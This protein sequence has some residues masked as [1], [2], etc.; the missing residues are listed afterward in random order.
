MTKEARH[1]YGPVP[2]RRLGLSLGV[3]IVPFNVCTLDCLY[4]QLGKTAEK[5]VQRKDYVPV[6]GVLTELRD[7]LAQGLEADYVTISGSGEPTL[8]RDLGKIVQNMKRITNIPVAIVTNGTLLYRQDVRT[9]CGDADVVLP[10]LDAGDEET[11]QRINQPHRDISIEKLITGLSTFRNE[12]GGQ[13]WLEVLFLEGI[14][15]SAE[16]IAG[17]KK[18]IERIRPHKVQLN[19]AVRPTALPGLRKVPPSK[20]QAIAAQLGPRAEVIADLGLRHSVGRRGTTAQD[21]LSMLKRRPCSLTEICSALGIA[22]NDAQKHIAQLREQGVIAAT[23]KSGITFLKA[24]E[25]P[26]NHSSAQ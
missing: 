1:L 11:F 20:L 8:H 21:V 18:A 12:F 17:I 9:D 19:T 15:T 5:T 4:C 25:G 3:D 13:I 14:N 6:E 26:N 24:A 10:S 2:S 7:R 22:Q 16:Q 23:V